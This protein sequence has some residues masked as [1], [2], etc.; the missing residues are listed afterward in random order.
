[1]NA[2]QFLDKVRKLDQM[3]DIKLD[4]IC[5]LRALAEKT[6]QAMSPESEHVIRTRDHTAVQETIARIVDAETELNR[7]ID[8]LVEMKKQASAI[9]DHIEDE[10][11][12]MILEMR[13]I[14]RMQWEDI[15]EIMNYNIR[16]V[17][18]MHEQGLQEMDRIIEMN[19]N[20]MIVHWAVKG[21]QGQ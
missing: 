1:M 5:R 13:Y 8:I 10:D 6:G 18:K 16:T 7:D 19:K 3:I 17:Y 4:R 2:K 20:D 14:A 9:L 21:M 15:A 11:C 12:R